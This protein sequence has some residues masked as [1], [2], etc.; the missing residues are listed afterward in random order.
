MS[1]FEAIPGITKDALWNSW[2]ETRRNLKRVPRRDILD[3]LEYDA[4][5]NVW[6]SRLLR[7]L[8]SGEYSPE[9]PTRY[10]V[11]KSKGFDRIITLPHIPDVVLYRAIVDH[12]FAKAKRKQKKHVYF[13]QATLSRVVRKIQKELTARKEERDGEVEYEAKSANVFEEWLKFDQYRRLL[14]FEEIFPFIVVTDITNFFESV[15]YGR[16]EAS[17]Y[18]L[19][20]SSRVVSLL[21]SLLENLSLREPLIPVQRIGLPVDP[22]EC[23]RTLAHMILFPHDDRIVNLVG[24]DAYVRWMDDQYIGVQSRAEGLRVLNK[25]GDSLRRLHLTP[26]AGKSNILS[27]AEAREHFHFNSNEGLDQLDQMPYS[28]RVQRRELERVLIQAWNRALDLEDVGEWQKI[29]GRFYRYTARARSRLLVDRAASDVV[30]FPGLTDRIADYMRYVSTPSQCFNF[31][32][33]LLQNQ[34]QVYSDI[35]YR[36]IESLLKLEP[37]A[38]VSRGLRRLAQRIM[39]NDIDFPGIEDC[40]ALAPLLLLRYGDRRNIRGLAGKLSTET[41]RLDPA[42]TRALCAVVSSTGSVGFRVVERTASR[43][44]RNNLSE[45][46][47]LVGRIRKFKAVPGRFKA[48]IAI[49]KDSITGAKYIDMRSYLAARILGLSTNRAVLNWL[50]SRKAELLDEEISRFERVL[51]LKLWPTT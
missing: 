32:T 47:R 38:T 31:V 33:A 20:V 50:R 11:A 10:P 19:P 2:R 43:L 29:L 24:E 12:L 37:Q 21:F 14:I 46:V 23:S 48:R 26:N 45:F 35:N 51:I 40:K 13:S 49:S 42:L 30:Q 18:G 17:L 41:E 27:L 44:L 3:F 25:V 6:I 5:P 7:R 16:I 28:T 8:R 4:D 36:L 22:C 34:E 39:K 9:K 1:V 15:L